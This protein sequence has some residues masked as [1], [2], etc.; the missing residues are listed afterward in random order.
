MEV[1][2]DSLN[3]R[4]Q[5]PITYLR[6][7]IGAI[8]FIIR[9]QLQVLQALKRTPREGGSG[10]DR[11]ISGILVP[12]EVAIVDEFITMATTRIKSFDE[13]DKRTTGFG[14]WVCQD[15]RFAIPLISLTI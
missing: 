8:T 12:R 13:I 1:T 6:Q 7:E 3:R 9:E 15:N 10:T 11:T 2:A 4:H 14:A 5:E